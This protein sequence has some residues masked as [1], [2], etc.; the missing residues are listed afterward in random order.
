LR[1]KKYQEEGSEGTDLRCEGEKTKTERE[2]EKER[3][4]EREKQSVWRWVV[5]TKGRQVVVR[6]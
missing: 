4:E 3:K 2:K 5:V 1:R 6:V